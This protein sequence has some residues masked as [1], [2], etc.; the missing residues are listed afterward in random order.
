MRHLGSPLIAALKLA[1]VVSTLAVAAA[2]NDGGGLIPDRDTTTNEQT[3]AYSMTPRNGARGTSLRVDLAAT[4]SRFEFGATELELGDGITI[5]SITVD[6]GFSAH[7]EISIDPDA[8]LGK[9]D[10]AI[11][12]DGTVIVLDDAFEVVG[13]SFQIDPVNGKMGETLYVSFVGQGTDWE[14]DYTWSSFGEGVEVLDFDVLSPTLAEARIAI[15]PDT[16]PGP[17]DV[18]TEDG[19]VVVTSYDAFTVDRAVITAFWDPVEA[20]QGRVVN[21][22][23]EGLDTSFTT[24]MT[25]EFWDDTG[26][27][28]D[29]KVTTVTETTVDPV[30]G[31]ETTVDRQNITVLDGENAYG[32]IRLSNAARI[33]MRDVLVTSANES[34]LIPD[35][36]EVLDAPPDLQYVY[37]VTRFDVARTIDNATGAEVDQVSA[38]AFFV[39]PLDPPCGAGAPPGSGPEPYDVNGVFPVPPEAEPVDCPYPETVSAGPFVWYVG[40]ENRVTLV[41]EVS[42]NSG[43]IYYRGIDLT[44][45]DYR[46]GTLYDLEAPGDPDGIPE[47]YVEDVQPTVPADYHITSPQLWGDYT[48]NRAGAFDYTW[49]PAQTYPEAIFVTNISGTLAV[50][51]EGG[52]AGALP[53]DDGE[54]SYKPAQLAQLND[55]PVTFSAVSY[56]EGPYWGL[57]FSSVQVAQSDSTLSTQAYMML[58]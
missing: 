35:A 28:A 34:I 7:A 16:A 20:Y 14:K 22:S 53:W 3:T 58:E 46:F 15:R 21:F 4:R 56:I 30:T 9:R 27:N 49:T 23:L 50:N 45:N 51:D 47:F 26:P 39:I 1:A 10:A 8:A 19:P 57:P 11:N 5:D 41:K 55:G 12:I 33:G 29:I 54:H 32:T 40:P 17:R 42:D 6:D 38:Q 13:E 37:P 48:H 36:M 2:C 31:V 25:I 18:S 43:Q 44:L 24:D 52:F